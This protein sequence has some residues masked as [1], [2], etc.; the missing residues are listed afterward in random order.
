MSKFSLESAR[1]N[2]QKVRNDKRV[3]LTAGTFDIIH[4]GHVD[5]L[6]WCKRR[7]DLLVVCVIGDKRTRQRKGPGRPVVKQEWRALMVSS[8]KP[9]DLVFVSNRRPFEEQII[10]AI[11]PTVVVTS[12]DEPSRETKAALASY[13]RAKNPEIQLIMRRRSS[14]PRKISTTNMIEKIGRL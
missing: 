8:L 11:R 14:F 1:L 2:L 3:I 6:Q 9:V 13:L 12:A 10:R 4:P 5:Y 7:G